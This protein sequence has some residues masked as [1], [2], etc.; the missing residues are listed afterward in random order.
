MTPTE[1]REAIL[2]VIA[3]ELELARADQAIKKSWVAHDRVS[4]PTVAKVLSGRRN[5]K[6]FTLL[7]VADALACDVEITIKRRA[8]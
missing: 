3:A 4:P 2:L 5:Y 7:E 1:R 8:S 6:L